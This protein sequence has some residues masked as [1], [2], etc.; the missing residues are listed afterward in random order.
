MW[1]KTHKT[2]VVLIPRVPVQPSIQEIRERHDRNFLRWMPHITL[3]YPFV[4]R[5]HFGAVL[6][7]LARVAA[8]MSVFSVLF[9]EFGLFRH[10]RWST[11][12]LEP[13]PPAEIG[14]LH[15]LL[16]GAF[17]DYA[18]TGR[19]R[20]GFRPHLSVGQFPKESAESERNRLG[21]AWCPVDCAFEEMSLIYRGPE[22]EDRFVV[23]ETFRF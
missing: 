9:S 22:T 23:A 20:G 19:F 16:V 15:N 8:E 17:P 4:P 12:F 14:R 1:G 21:G 2:A 11:L 7:M 10:R 3:V 6:P 18:D 5:E 13:T